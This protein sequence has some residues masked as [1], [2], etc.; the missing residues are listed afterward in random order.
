MKRIK[1]IANAYTWLT[2]GLAGGLVVQKWLGLLSWS[3][4]WVTAPIWFNV[5]LAVALVLFAKVY[6]HEKL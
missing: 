5:I 3:W 6:L 1:R 2:F 4:W